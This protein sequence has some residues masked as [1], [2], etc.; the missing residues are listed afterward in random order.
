[1]KRMPRLMAPLVAAALLAVPRH[2]AAQADSS[3]RDHDRAA[4]AAIARSDW[5][6]A[7]RHLVIMDRLLGGHPAVAV[8]LARVA[9]HQADTAEAIRQFERVA[10]MGVTSRGIHD[11]VFS[12]LQSRSAF[13]AAAAAIAANT[14][15]IGSAEV[16]ATLPDTNAIAEDLAWDPA[17]RRFIVS[18][19]RGHR[20]LTVTLEGRSAAFGAPLPP[21]WAVLGVAADPRRRILWASTVTLPQAAGYSAADSGHAAILML[22]LASGALRRRFD[23]PVPTRIAPGDLAVAEN[24]D[25]FIGDGM[26]GTIQVIRA[27]R[28]TLTMLVPAGSFRGSQQPAIAP[29]GRTVFI[30]D[31]GRGIARV[32]RR[33]GAVRWLARGPDVSLTGIDGLLW[34]G[35]ALVAVQNGVT[36]NRVV[37][38]TL[39][40]AMDSIT[41]AAILLRDSI[42]APEPTHGAVVGEFLYLIGNA[43]WSKYDERGAPAA[44][45]KRES[46]RIVRLPLLPGT[47]GGL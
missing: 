1:M 19:V 26:T 2:A 16:V 14:T 4:D 30:A 21:G 20:L 41:G 27:G 10:A 34:S 8:A 15:T 47:S 43:G 44:G 5:A 7:K 31:Y 38:L 6:G 23:L 37:R 39:N 35:R 12:G 17:R 13:Q 25:L 22:D 46:P 32:D 24:G 33:T 45:V 3:W 36:P 11:T 40:G 28:E 29:D 18:D 42:S 9:V